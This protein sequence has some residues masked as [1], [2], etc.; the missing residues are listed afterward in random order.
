MRQY[1]SIFH[2]CAAAEFARRAESLEVQGGTWKQQ[3][4]PH[5]SVVIG[6]I[7]ESAS[8]LESAINELLQDA[9]DGVPFRVEALGGDCAA[10]LAAYWLARP[11]ETLRKYQDVLRVAG[12]E[13]F[14]RS[15][16]PFADAQ[17]LMRLRNDLHH[18]KPRTVALGVV[19]EQRGYDRLQRLAQNPW[20][21]PNNPIFPD[22]LLCHAAAAWAVD[23]AIAL[24]SEF[25]NRIGIASAHER[26]P[27]DRNPR[28]A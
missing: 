21:S 9:E 17:D 14:D 18:F 22:R 4:F 24:V 20:M 26:L 5:T 6:S 1:L 19:G 11:R 23:S 28:L 27:C 16:P 15:Q 7:L 3:Q 8:F 13:L 2:L 12:A 25:S 10:R